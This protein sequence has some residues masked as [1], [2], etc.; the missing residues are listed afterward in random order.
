VKTSG[1]HEG[2]LVRT[3]SGQWITKPPARCPNGHSLGPNQVLV[4]HVACLGD[5]GGHTTWTCRVCDQTVF[6]P[7][8]NTHCA[9]LEGPAT[10][11]IST[12]PG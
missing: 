6:G 8:L 7:P 3:T 4:G 11:R 1:V 9:T 12:Q 2:E 10:V 5:G